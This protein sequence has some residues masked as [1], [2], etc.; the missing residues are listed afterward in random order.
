[1]V[2]LR[3]VLVGVAVH[4]TI[5][6]LWYSPLL[7]SEP[8]MRLAFPGKKRPKRRENEGMALAFLGSLV[9]V[10]VLC[11]LLGVVGARNAGEGALWGLA[12]ALLD[13]GLHACH[14]AFENR[15]FGLYVMHQSYHTVSLIL[16]GAVLG[17]LFGS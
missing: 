8:F 11:F 12:L 2:S 3:A 16:T 10:P 17:A 15:P 13:A 7:F 9:H 1:M 5:G 4:M 6:G 14:H